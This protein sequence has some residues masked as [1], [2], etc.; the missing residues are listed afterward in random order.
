MWILAE[1]LRRIEINYKNKCFPLRSVQVHDKYL[2][3]ELLYPS[4]SIRVQKLGM[5]EI[6]R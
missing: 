2:L 4:T 3:R 5:P 6:L 1:I